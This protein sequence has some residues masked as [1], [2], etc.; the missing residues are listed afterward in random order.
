MQITDSIMARTQPSSPAIE[1]AESIEKSQHSQGFCQVFDEF[2]DRETMISGREESD[3]DLTIFPENSDQDD[4]DQ[5]EI[6]DSDNEVMDSDTVLGGESDSDIPI[7]AYGRELPAGDHDDSTQDPYGLGPKT[8]NFGSKIDETDLPKFVNNVGSNGEEQVSKQRIPSSIE[9]ALLNEMRADSSGKLDLSGRAETALYPRT[10]EIAGVGEITLPN[11]SMADSENISTKLGRSDSTLMLSATQNDQD[12]LAAPAS[13][14]AAKN[15]EIGSGSP[16]SGQPH[17]K[18]P[19]ELGTGSTSVEPSLR[20]TMSQLNQR[21]P[22]QSEFTQ[23]EVRPPSNAVAETVSLMRSAFQSR[24]EIPR[25]SMK[26]EE[27]SKAGFEQ[28]FEARHEARFANVATAS[29]PSIRQE[30]SQTV[31]RQMTDAVRAQVTAEKTV[32]IALRPAELGR[33]RIALS[34]AETGMVVTVSAERSETLELMRRNIDDL[35]RSFAEM[36]H[37]NLSFNF[38]QNGAHDQKD[39]RQLGADHVVE[40]PQNDSISNLENPDQTPILR[41][42]STGVDILV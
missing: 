23:N 28:S 22:V 1:R 35:A 30:M 24:E 26:A 17:V 19:Q 4:Q 32:E 2:D 3:S 14:S 16:L 10:P 33:V 11:S 25:L 8:N 42:Q 34:P 21:E 27:G 29:A 40:K 31:I 18:F 15:L 9:A 5:V 7:N 20:Q 6:D 41:T 13:N 37:E 38:E 12:V 36:G 39:D